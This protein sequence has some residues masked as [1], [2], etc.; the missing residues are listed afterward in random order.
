MAGPYGSDVIQSW[1]D[2]CKIAQVMCHSNYPDLKNLLQS[3]KIFSF[4]LTEQCIVHE[5]H[6]GMRPL[7]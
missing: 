6:A 2:N 4:Q 3:Q 7:Q 1:G 5:A